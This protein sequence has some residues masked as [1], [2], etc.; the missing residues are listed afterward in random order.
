MEKQI[1]R[2]VCQVFETAEG[3]VRY[4]GLVTKVKFHDVY[5][6]WMYHVEYEDRDSVDN[7]R[8]K[9]V[10]LFCRCGDEFFRVK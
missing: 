5:S 10:L 3:D 2:V 4:H 1:G 9:L 7:W 6:Q 8:H